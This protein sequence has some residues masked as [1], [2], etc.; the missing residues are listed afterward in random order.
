[1]LRPGISEMKYLL[2]A[3]LGRRCEQYLLLTPLD[4]FRKG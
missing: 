2:K 4:S 3:I 1:M